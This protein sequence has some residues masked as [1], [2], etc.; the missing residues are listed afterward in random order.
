MGLLLVVSM[1]LLRTPL[2]SSHS[3]SLGRE[4]MTLNKGML[5]ALAIAA[6]ANTG[7]QVS[8][9]NLLVDPSF[10]GTITYDGPPF[11]GFWEGFSSSPGVTSGA[12]FG[13]GAARTGSQ[14]T[15]LFIDNASNQ[16]AGV[17]Q[18][19]LVSAGTPVTFAIWHED[20]LGSNGQG[21]EMRMEYR[22][23]ASN[24]EI[25][26]TVNATPV[27]LGADYEKFSITGIV[28]TAADT[29]RAVYAIQSFGGVKSQRIYL[30]DASLTKVVPEPTSLYLLVIGIAGLAAAANR[31]HRWSK[32]FL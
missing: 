1:E 5:A 3:F 25:S 2:L 10:E 12:G 9:Q 6:I 28:P 7:T 14:Q 16:F 19:V 4:L 27:S 8:A 13:T 29:V 15:T 17:F 31:R 21:I 22:N 20:V 26:R 30:D 24:V 18:D 11:I 32:R 23:S